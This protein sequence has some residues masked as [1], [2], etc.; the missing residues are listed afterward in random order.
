MKSAPVKAFLTS[1]K[2]RTRTFHG[3]LKLKENGSSI[4][5]SSLETIADVLLDVVEVKKLFCDL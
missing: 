4:S 1:G 2:S 5:L 3:K